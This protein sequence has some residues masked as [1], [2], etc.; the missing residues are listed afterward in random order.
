MLRNREKTYRVGLR[1]E[2][3]SIYALEMLAGKFIVRYLKADGSHS[4]RLIFFKNSCS[5]DERAY[6]PKT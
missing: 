6:D 5:T 2:L 3:E 1:C 4:C